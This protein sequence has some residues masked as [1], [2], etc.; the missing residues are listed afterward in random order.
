[1]KIRPVG[2][3]LCPGGRRGRATDRHDEANSRFF[4]NFINASKKDVLQCS[5]SAVHRR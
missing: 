5:I 2:P 1:M 4:P 3:E